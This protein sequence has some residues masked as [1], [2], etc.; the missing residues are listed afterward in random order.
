[1]A[2]DKPHRGWVD[3]LLRPVLP[4]GDL[5]APAAR[6]HLPE[7]LGWEEVPTAANPHAVQALVGSGD[8]SSTRPVRALAMGS[9][10]LTGW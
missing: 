1:M 9:H 10:V 3:E 4:V 5:S 7:A 6:Q 2:I 8:R